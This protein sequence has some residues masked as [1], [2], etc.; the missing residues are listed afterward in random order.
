MQIKDCFNKAANQYDSHC[1]LQLHTGERLIGLIEPADKVIDL[2]CGSGITTCKLKYKKLYALDIA[3]KLLEKAKIRLSDN[4]VTFLEDS[5][6]NFSG[7]KLDLA[8]AN[9]SLQWSDDLKFTLANIKANLNPQG[10]LAFSI[11]LVGTFANIKASRMSFYSIKQI[12]ELL[13]DWQI[14]HSE[15]EEISYV[16]PSLVDSLRSIKAIGAN[17]CKESSGRLISR[18]KTAHSL[19]YSI[20]YFVVKRL[21]L[22]YIDI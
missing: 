13:E 10:V 2:G 3:D 7:L 21:D 17:Y 1:Q 16:F 12:K 11:P 8:F 22:N 9:M 6:D 20:G 19:K 18:D 4:D 15:I 14:I 5:F